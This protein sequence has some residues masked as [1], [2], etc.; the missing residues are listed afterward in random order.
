[1]VARTGGATDQHNGRPRCGPHNRCGT[2]NARRSVHTSDGN[3]VDLRSDGA[4][5]RRIDVDGTA[6]P[7][8]GGV[9]VD[10]VNGYRIARVDVCRLQLPE[11]RSQLAAAIHP[12]SGSE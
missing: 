4:G 6:P 7:D 12:H 1:M 10:D 2:A 3:F 8:L 5:R 11:T 9:A